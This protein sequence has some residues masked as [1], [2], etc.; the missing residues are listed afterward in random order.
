M[1]TIDVEL[2]DN[3]GNSYSYAFPAKYEVCN[4][5]GGD[6]HHLNPNIE[7]EGGGF[8]ASEWRDACED[9]PEFEEHYFGGMYD[10]TCSKCKGKRVMLV[11]DEFAIVT[12][13][14]KENF[15]LYNKQ[16][17]EEYACWC[18]RESERRMGC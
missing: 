3:D 10:I 8:T 9:D 16:Q 7:C 1:K 12:D 18:E 15:N 6:G 11:I 13:E 2:Y 4:R 17:E 14:Q 5:C